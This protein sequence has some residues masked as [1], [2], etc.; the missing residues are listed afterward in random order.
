M[1][2][3]DLLPLV[4]MV[5][6][7]VAGAMAAPPACA[8]TE[9]GQDR[10][11]LAGAFAVAVAIE[12]GVTV[13]VESP[14]IDRA[15]LERDE[16][17]EVLRLTSP[18]ERVMDLKGEA[19]FRPRPVYAVL[20]ALTQARLRRGLLRDDIAER[21]AAT[22]TAVVCWDAAGFP[23]RARAF[24]AASYVPVGRWRVAGC[25]IEPDTLRGGDRTFRLGVSQR[26][27]IVTA[28][29]P[30]TGTL[31]GAPYQGPRWLPAGSH[32]YRPAPGEGPVA[33]VW[34]PA[35]ERGFR[36]RGLDATSR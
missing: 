23:P 33:A 21:L 25:L 5:A 11:W 4:P 19:I 30:A 1:T 2:R 3:Q 34:A 29:E 8:P 36:P 17:A 24:M 12:L 7:L 28:R 10:R 15:R 26:Y 22:R 9:T 13:A 20:E 35:I 16:L 31:D 32:V 18:G 6:T 14:W 27:A